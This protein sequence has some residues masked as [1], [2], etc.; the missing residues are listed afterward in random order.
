MRLDNSHV[1]AFRRRHPRA[2][3]VV[4]LANF[5]DFDEGV[6]L[7]VSAFRHLHSSRGRLE[8]GEGRVWLEPWGYLW[9][10]G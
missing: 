1:L 4:V 10:L 3:P 6:G 2:A 8:A 5:S 7:D 9:L